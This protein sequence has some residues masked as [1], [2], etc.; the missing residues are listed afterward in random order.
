MP[1]ERFLYDPTLDRALNSLSIVSRA[2]LL[3]LAL[4]VTYTLYFTLFVLMR[5]HSLRAAHDDTSFRKSLAVLAHRSTNLRQIIVAIFYLFG[6]TFFLQIQNAFWT[7][8]NNRPVGLMVLENFRGYFRFGAVIFL[9][10]LVLHSAQWFV[11]RRIRT[12]TLRLD[13]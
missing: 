5:L 10:F 9:V 6:L 8:D 2:F 13:T 11:S 7:P 3:F 12:A 4:V 1:I